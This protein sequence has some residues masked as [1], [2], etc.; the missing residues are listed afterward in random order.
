M[1]GSGLKNKNG[2]IHKVTEDVTD[3]D[4]HEQKL[5]RGLKNRHIQLIAI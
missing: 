5:S 3:N 1:R 4:I 2:S